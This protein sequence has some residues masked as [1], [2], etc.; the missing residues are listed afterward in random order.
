[1]IKRFLALSVLGIYSGLA[2]SQNSVTLYGILDEGILVN[3]NASGHRQYEMVSGVLSGSRFGFSGSEDLGGGLHAI[4]VL[5]N[6]FDVNGGSLGN[7]GLLFGRQAYVGLS[8]DKFGSATLGRQYDSSIDYVGRLATTAQ[9]G[10]YITTNP[11]DDG[12][13]SAVNHVNNSIKYASPNIAGLTFGGL[14]SLGGVAGNLTQNQIYSVGAGY[15]NGP[16]S[17]GASYVNVRD[18]NASFFAT[19]RAGTASTNN[20]YT[21][22]N[23]GYAS[24]HTLQIADIAVNYVLGKASL[25]ANYSNAQFKGLSGAVGLLNPGGVRG[26]A[27]LNDFAVNLR[28]SITPSLLVAVQ[29]SHTEGS[30][31][32]GA[33]G[34]KYNQFDLGTVYSLSKRTDLYATAAYQIASGTQSTGTHAVASI[35]GLTPSSTNHQAAFRLAIRHKF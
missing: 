9:W 16:V 29:A 25:G 8:S 32:N 3:Q 35:F 5:E 1:M 11:G 14:Y 4:F 6:G 34:A 33:S 22:I 19:S 15:A 10:G 24:A 2:Y 31:V 28:Y 23:S 21:P 17:V 30:S 12:D 26:T 20:F 18:P 7:G 13:Y 27:T